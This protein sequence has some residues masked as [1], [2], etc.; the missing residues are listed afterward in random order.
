VNLVA[1]DHRV[2][3][4][5]PA[6]LVDLRSRSGLVGCVENEPN[7]LADR[8]VTHVRVSQ[9][10]ECP[11]NGGALGIGD[12]GKVSDLDSG[13]VPHASIVPV[14]RYDRRMP[15]GEEQRVDTIELFFDLVFVFT[16]TQLT[17]LLAA[18]PDWIGIAKVMLIF[19]NVFW[20]YDGYV[21][22][23]NAVPPR[24][25]P[26]RL[27]LLLGMVGFLII[28]L[29]I[30]DAFGDTGVAFGVGYLLVTI[31]HAGLFLRSTEVSTVRSVMRLGPFNL[32]TAIVI[33]LAGFTDDAWQWGAWTA[34]FVIHWL[35]PAVAG[36]SGFRVRTGHFVER[37]GL[38]VLI[39]LGESIVAIG[40]GIEGA[41]VTA[42]VLLTASLGLA[43]AA[44]LWWLYFDGEDA[45]AEAA[46]NAAAPERRPWLAVNAFG[47]T[48]FAVLG[49][50]IVLATGVKDALAHYN[51]PA[52]AAT[53]W[54]L[55]AGVATYVGGLVL[56]RALLGTGPLMLRG[57]VGALALP[58]AAV[59]V[60]V[61]PEAQLAVL[62]V[63][64]VGGIAVESSMRPRG[65]TRRSSRP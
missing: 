36:V 55:A 56:F 38:I 42:G 64:L 33:L 16:I 54:F 4:Q 19:G 12:A 25:A 40:I 45:A 11:L 10:G 26:A 1:L 3:E 22:V 49:G 27:F 37:H 20:I 17:A 18:E 41:H 52:T 7:A 14:R 61:S 28:A 13:F 53:A 8:D 29:A 63:V 31:V 60:G 57:V 9:R 6:H 51:E 2:G 39:A 30:P 46:L 24:A 21:W 35:T 47:F 44:A 65:A 15:E 43:V 48:F 50:I 32:V 62:V 5:S 23:T 34:A 58:T 59:G